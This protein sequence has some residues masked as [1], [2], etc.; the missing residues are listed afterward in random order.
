LS[1][2]R[3]GSFKMKIAGQIMWALG[4]GEKMVTN[5]WASGD[6]IMLSNGKPIINTGKQLYLIGWI[7]SVFSGQEP[8]SGIEYSVNVYNIEE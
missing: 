5:G 2:S 1:L 7:L 3:L 4:P 6:A 8:L